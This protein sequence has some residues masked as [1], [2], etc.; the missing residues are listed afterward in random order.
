MSSNTNITVLLPT[1]NS[2]K[3]IRKTLDSISWANEVIMIDSFSDD[4]TL[5]IAKEFNNVNIIQHEYINSAKQK[6]WAL[7]HCSNDWILQIDSDELLE[8][9]SE[10]IIKEAI[11][12]VNRNVGC[13]RL[14]RKNFV[15]GKWIRYGG[16]YPD[17]Q[18]RLFKKDYAKWSNREVHARL[19]VKGDIQTLDLKIIH[20]GMPNISKQLGNLNRYSR[21]EADEMH[22]KDQSFIYSKWIIGA[23]GVFLKKYFIQFGFLDGWRGLLMAVYTAFYFFISYA[24]LL[25]LKIL[26]LEK[27]PN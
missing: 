15:L 7:R 25:E 18:Y 10:N 26:K 1:F 5:D 27:S 20:F 2:E 21:Y 13:F 22:K 11:K 19:Q 6:N 4:S 24:K 3:T 12:K 23:L 14:K 9:N 8:N 17:W 16:F